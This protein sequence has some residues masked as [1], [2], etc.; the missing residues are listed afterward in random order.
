MF[1]NMNI[2]GCLCFKYI[3][4]FGAIEIE[5]DIDLMGDFWSDW[6]GYPRDP[7]PKGQAMFR[8]VHSKSLRRDL[9]QSIL[10][11]CR[12]ADPEYRQTSFYPYKSCNLRPAV[13]SGND[14]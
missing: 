10:R 4:C 13:L 2:F 1:E 12:S 5:I 7:P 14:F 8:C 9:L 11:R 3:I 6:L